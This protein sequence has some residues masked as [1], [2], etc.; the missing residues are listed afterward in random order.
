MGSSGLCA[1]SPLKSDT[2]RYFTPFQD[3]YDECRSTLP[4]LQAHQ[5]KQRLCGFVT[6]ITCKSNA[7][8]SWDLS[9]FQEP[10]QARGTVSSGVFD[11]NGDGR[12]DANEC[13]SA[14]CLLHPYHQPQTPQVS[15]GAFNANQEMFR[16]QVALEEQELLR[17]QGLITAIPV[18]G[19]SNNFECSQSDESI[20]SQLA[21]FDQYGLHDG[22]RDDTDAQVG[23]GSSGS[24]CSKARKHPRARAPEMRPR[25]LQIDGILDQVPR[26]HIPFHNELKGVEPTHLQ[27]M[28]NELE[29]SAKN[30]QPSQTSEMLVRGLHGQR[31]PGLRSSARAMISPR[32]GQGFRQRPPSGMA[33]GGRVTE[34]LLL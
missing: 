16:L 32:D 26:Y 19:S 23:W 13:Y 18:G 17:Q 8:A 34:K 2:E 14:V 10:N 3:G 30:R 27:V 29:S 11:V 33:N 7:C 9:R 21:Q 5:Q 1:Q 31:H 24:C 22:I 4:D 20:S 6:D 28:L 25:H 15:A 12:V